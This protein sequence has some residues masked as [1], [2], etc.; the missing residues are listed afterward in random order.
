MPLVLPPGYTPPAAPT[1]ITSGKLRVKVDTVNKGVWLKADYSIQVLNGYLQTPVKIVFYRQDPDGSIHRVRSGDPYTTYSG[2]AW[3]YDHEAPLGVPVRYWAEPENSTWTPGQISRA[4]WTVLASNSGG[5][6]PASGAIDGVPY[7]T[8]DANHWRSG[9]NLSSGMWFMIGFGVPRAWDSITLDTGVGFS[10]DQ[11]SG[12]TIDWSN[13][14]T[15]WNN[16]NG[17][18]ASAAQQVTLNASSPK[19]SKFVRVTATSSAAHQWTID[20]INVSYSGAALWTTDTPIVVTIP[21]PVGGADDPALL[22]K[23]LSNSRTSI[24]PM[25]RDTAKVNLPGRT[26]VSQVLGSRYPSATFAQRSARQPWQIKF[27]TWTMDQFDQVQELADSKMVLV[28]SSPDQARRDGYFA[29]KDVSAQRITSLSNQTV[30]EWQ[31]D[32]IEQD[33]PPTRN[34]TL[35]VPGYSF[36]EDGGQDGDVTNPTFGAATFWDDGAAG[37]YSNQLLPSDAK[38]D[39]GS[40]GSWVGQTNCTVALDT[41]TFLT[42]P[43]SLKIFPTTNALAEA[44]LNPSYLGVGGSGL[45]SFQFWAF[46]PNPVTMLIDWY[47]SG[48][49]FISTSTSASKTSSAGVWTQLTYNVQA[50]A[51]AILAVPRIQLTFPGPFL[52]A[53]N[54]DRIVWSKRKRSQIGPYNEFGNTFQWAAI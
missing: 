30:F 38:F 10:G 26:D 11:I 40:V 14:G 18:T 35:D 7:T 29:I 3:A 15:T 19:V 52:N 20:E 9:S 22:I 54:V 47:D 33:R 13:N 27:L 23:S 25:A 50:P 28:Q 49:A 41:S 8:N 2:R 48:N 39:S 21:A 24:A 4:G 43:A 17:G 1:D 45:Y 37:P 42:A 5:T 12:W 44:R 51:T 34:S 32:L 31:F 46:G 6:T 53:L 36:Y 16:L